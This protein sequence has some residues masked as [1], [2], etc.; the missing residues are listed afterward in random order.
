MPIRVARVRAARAVA[1]VGACCAWVRCRLVDSLRRLHGEAEF[2]PSLQRRLH[3]VRRERLG[4]GAVDLDEPVLAAD[5][6]PLAL[7]VGVH[8][9]DA[10]HLRPGHPAEGAELRLHEFVVQDLGVVVPEPDADD[11]VLSFHC[12]L[13]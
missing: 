12:C 2:A 13:F 9:Q 10:G 6:H 4:V 5:A 7:G 1:W 11:G 8:V 3:A